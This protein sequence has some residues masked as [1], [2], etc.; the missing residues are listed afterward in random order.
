MLVTFSLPEFSLKKHMCSSLEFHV[1]DRPESSNT[2]DMIIN[3]KRNLF[4][5]LGIIMNVN[6]DMVTYLDT[7]TIIV[8]YRDKCTLSS[9]VALI[10]IDLSANGPQ[11]LMMNILGLKTFLI[12]GISKYLQA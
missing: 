12:L 3:Q 9:V 2:Y 8:K 5:G 4:E 1:D 11:T 10:E 6:D 7:D